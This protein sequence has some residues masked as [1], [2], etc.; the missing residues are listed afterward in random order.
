[1]STAE[2]ILQVEHLS[3]RFGG[4]V[5]VDDLS[6]IAQRGDITA[7]IGP[8]G[9]GKTTVFNCI[10][11]FYK[12][13]AGLIRLE[14]PDGR[15]FLLERLLNFRV[16]KV[17][18]VARTF[19]NIRLFPGMTVLENL[20]VAQHNALM[21][22]SGF[23]F[24]GLFGLKSYRKAENAALDKARYWLDRTGLLPR[25]DDAA[26]ALAYGEQRRLE[27]A[28]AMCTDPVLLCLDEPAAGLNARESAEL[29]AL[30]K[31]IRR[32]HAI[33][34]LLIEH[35]MSVVMEISDHIVVLDYGIKIADGTPEAIR[36]DPKVIAAYLGVED[37][38][39]EKVEAE[40]E[41]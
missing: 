15:A 37:D 19:Q 28:R 33:S 21:L 16:A 18:R 23:S 8:N 34:I 2:P 14:H 30:L 22:A 1:M 11:G 27:I 41:L 17:A 29:N 12:P 31:F 7:L 5:A 26:G 9:A 20:V 13:T 35:D 38:E 6:F 40:V 39:V 3:M 4:L 25:A 10:T 32:E 36:N 24:A